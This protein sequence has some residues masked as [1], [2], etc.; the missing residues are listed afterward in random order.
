MQAQ[1]R[2]VDQRHFQPREYR[3][4]RS[5]NNVHAVSDRP[6][7]IREGVAIVAC[8]VPEQRP[9]G[10]ANYG[11]RCWWM[12]NF[13]KSNRGGLTDASNASSNRDMSTTRNFRNTGKSS[14]RA[15]ICTL[16]FGN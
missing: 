11:S 15:P 3:N 13:R 5:R 6:G 14:A 2:V 7:S 12:M 10:V 1:F 16:P 8:Q 9:G 4:V